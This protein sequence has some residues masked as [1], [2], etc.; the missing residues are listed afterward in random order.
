MGMGCN[1]RCGALIEWLVLW[2]ESH[3]VTCIEI[4]CSN[5]NTVCTSHTY[6]IV[7]STCMAIVLFRRPH[8]DLPLDIWI[9]RNVQLGCAVYNGAAHIVYTYAKLQFY[10]F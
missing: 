3:S 6:Y 4:L 2:H 5:P 7:L 10:S 8:L 9:M 1:G